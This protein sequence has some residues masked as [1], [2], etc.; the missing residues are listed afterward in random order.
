MSLSRSHPVV[1]LSYVHDDDEACFGFITRLREQLEREIR[2]TLGDKGFAIFH[3]RKDIKW[4]QQWKQRLQ[5]GVAGSTLFL[6]VATPLYFESDACRDELTQFLEHERGLNRDDLILP[7]YLRPVDDFNAQSADKLRAALST[8]QWDDWSK[9]RREGQTSPAYLAALDRA[10]ERIADLVRQTHKPKPAKT[11]QTDKATSGGTQT[12]TADSTFPPAREIPTLVVDAMGRGD[13]RT[14]SAA[15]EAAE[16]GARILIRPG[17][18]DETLVLDKPLELI[19]DGAPGTIS[20][21]RKDANV[22]LARTAMGRI[23]NLTIRQLGGKHY[24]IKIGQGRVEIE[25]CDVTSLGLAAIAIFEHADPVLRRNRIHNSRMSGIFIYDGGRGTIEDNDIFANALAGIEIKAEADPVIRRNRIH[26][27]KQAAIM[28][29]AHGG[30]TIE[31]NDVFANTF[32]GIEIKREASPTIRNNIIRDGLQSGIYLHE[33]GFGTI[34]NNN[35]HGNHGSGI[36]VESGS[37]P[38]V[39]GNRICGNKRVGIKIVG[40]GGTY[41]GNDLRNNADGAFTIDKDSLK[42][43]V[44]QDNQE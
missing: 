26:H 12:K 44:R 24:A 37:K 2:A 22:I 18:Y 15:I 11:G 9:L 31:D 36:W 30:G 16:P 4:G 38:H 41:R 13:H 3:D 7:L 1:F 17:Q 5:D 39:T 6:P 21:V 35:I 33:I 10:A 19:G 27:G 28:V 40:A 25:E 23:S 29:S 42:N 43:A 34:E 8:H 14:I 32:S 20:V